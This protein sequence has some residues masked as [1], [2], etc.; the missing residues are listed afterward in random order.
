MI[1]GGAVAT[2]FA[3]Q[4]DGGEP[5]TFAPTNARVVRHVTF[6]KLLK[7]DQGSYYVR[8]Y[9]FLV[10]TEKRSHNVLVKKFCRFW[11]IVRDRGMFGGLSATRSSVSMVFKQTED[12]RD[13]ELRLE[14]RECASR[15]RRDWFRGEEFREFRLRFKFVEFEQ[16]VQT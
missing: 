7:V 8:G 6:Q 4:F 1:F 2:P 9:G 11:E 3:M 12:T 16:A 13:G 5:A 15:E 10:A 14:Q